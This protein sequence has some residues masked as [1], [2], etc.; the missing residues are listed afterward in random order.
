MP[1]RQELSGARPE[2]SYHTPVMRDRIVE[3]LD[4]QPGKVLVDATLGGGGHAAALVER[5]LPGGL[6]I[7]IDQDPDAISEVGKRLAP[8]GSAVRLVASRFDRIAQ[9]LDDLGIVE[10]DGAVFDL[11]V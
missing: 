9:I 2:S 7:G 3:L 6:L 4:P 10:V 8:Y 5:L 11:G 1:R